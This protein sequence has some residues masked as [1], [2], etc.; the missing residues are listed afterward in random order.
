M[1]KAIWQL[2]PDDLIRGKRIYRVISKVNTGG[3]HE[4]KLTVETSD[5]HHQTVNADMWQL[6]EV[7]TVLDQLAEIDPA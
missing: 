6:V 3:R 7:A 5:G 2:R 4:V 1:L